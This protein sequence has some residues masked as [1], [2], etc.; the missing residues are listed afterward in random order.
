MKKVAILCDFDGTVARDDV[1][2]LLFRTFADPKGCCEAVEEWKNGLITSRDCLER[3]ASLARV[4][5]ETLD[6]FIT[7]RK[8]DPYFKDFV[9]FA[10]RRGMEAR[11]RERRSRLLHREDARARRVSAISDFFANALH[12]NDHSLH[13]DFPYFDMLDCRSCGNCKRYAHGEVQDARVLRR[14]HRE[15]ALRPLPAE[16]R[17]PRFRQGGSARLLPGERRR[18]RPSSGTSAT[19]SARSSLASCLPG[20]WRRTPTAEDPGIV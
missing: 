10:H 17:R 14:V 4:S 19:S 20:S 8:L 12:M 2:N 1:G 11:H 5:R 16:V 15:R 7:Q 6:G 3:E 13:V 9:D 18:P